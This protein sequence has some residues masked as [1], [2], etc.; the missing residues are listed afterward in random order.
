MT[1]KLASIQRIINI[2][3]IDGADKI[4]LATVQGW[5]CVVKKGEF[6]IGDMVIYI[7]IDAEL[8]E[9]LLKIIGF[10]DEIK[11]IGKLNGNKGNRVKT[12]K[13]RGVLSQGL[14]INTTILNNFGTL[15][16]KSN[17]FTPNV[18]N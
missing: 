4:E 17:T 13:F 1:R 9:K 11:N 3:P 16:T 2:A 7:E 6:K 15:D 18:I 8:C 14:I 12:R 10:W 5:E